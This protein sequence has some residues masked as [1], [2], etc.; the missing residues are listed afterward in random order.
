MK[1]KVAIIEC[2]QY[3]SELTD[4]AV[5]AA[6]ELLGGWQEFVSKEEHII[7]KPNLLARCAPEKACT[8]HPQV[9]AAVGKGLLEAGYKNLYYGDSPGNHLIGVEQTAEGCGIRQEAEALDIFPANFS[10]GQQVPFPQGYAADHFVLCKGVLEADAI[11]NICKMK[12]H[13]LERITGAMKNT[14]GCVYGFNKGASHARFPNADSFGKMI[15]D[16]NRLVKP[17]LHI[18]DGIMAMEGNGPQSGDPVPMGVIAA[19]A[20]PVALDSLFCRL[21]HLDPALVATNVYGQKF[22]IGTYEEEQIQLVTEEGE[23]SMEEAVSRWGNPD[24]KVEREA[25]F[26]GQLNS[27]SFLQ[28][29]LDRKPYVKKEKCVGCGICVKACPVEPKAI[30]FRGG[31]PAYHYRRCIKCYCCQEMCPKKAI[32]VKTTRLA[33]LADRNWRI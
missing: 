27:I 10:E 30:Y 6:V 7:L 14:F 9:F 31:K 8:T 32:G 23:I 15:G 17:R 22:G 21:V 2:R 12:T 3:R 19:S 18:M 5:S 11:I 16:L 25:E 1:S 28:P 20:D 24:F 26:R 33:K 29:L 13:Q 4:R